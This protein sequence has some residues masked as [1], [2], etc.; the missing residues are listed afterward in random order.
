MSTTP[1][2]TASRRLFVVAANTNDPDMRSL[3]TQLLDDPDADV[4][5]VLRL[6][7]MFMR[8]VDVLP[9]ATRNRIIAE[10]DSLRASAIFSDELHDWRTT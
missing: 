5:S 4:V 1:T 6:L 2:P 8:R 9:E 10:L 7:L 3:A